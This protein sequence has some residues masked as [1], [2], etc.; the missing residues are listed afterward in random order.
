L[1][2]LHVGTPPP[3][4]LESPI[5]AP[6]LPKEWRREELEANLRQ[7]TVPNLA[8]GLEHR[9]EYAGSASDEILRVAEEIRA[10][11]IVLGTHGRKG[12]SRLL[13]GSVAEQVLRRAR[14]P[15][16]SVRHLASAEETSSP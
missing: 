14:C 16:V 6:P 7:R 5:S 12:L 15:V 10:D 11:L 8:G 3:R 2:V 13:L 9:L 4:A 1:V